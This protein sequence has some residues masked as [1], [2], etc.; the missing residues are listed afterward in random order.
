[1]LTAIGG[2]AARAHA[3]RACFNTAAH[4]SRSSTNLS[5]AAFDSSRIGVT[6]LAP[7]HDVRYGKPLVD[8]AQSHVSHIGKAQDAF[9]RKSI[10]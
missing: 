4:H 6:S 7:L 10:K 3:A 2:A 9:D 1:M 8:W 5:A